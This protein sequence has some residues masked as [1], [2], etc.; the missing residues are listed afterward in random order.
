[1]VGGLTV[2]GRRR[3]G[4]PWEPAAPMRG[5]FETIGSVRLLGARGS[6]TKEQHEAYLGLDR[7]PLQLCG[8]GPNY[9]VEHPW[10]RTFLA[11]S[12]W[13]FQTPGPTIPQHVVDVKSFLPEKQVIE[14]GPCRYIE[15]LAD[16]PTEYASKPPMHADRRYAT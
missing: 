11:R 1:M 16:N 9:G 14:T 5:V 2:R 7:A 4:G 12:P 10:R 6:R 15:H 8:T 13:W 3:S